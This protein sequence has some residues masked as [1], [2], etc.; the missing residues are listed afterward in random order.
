MR[1]KQFDVISFGTVYLDIDFLEFPFTEG[2]FAHRETVGKNYALEVGGSA[3]NFAKICANLNQSVLFIGQIGKDQIAPTVQALAKK[4]KVKTH[5]IQSSHVQ[6]NLAMHYVHAN[7]ESIMTS[8]G[9]ANQ[10]LSP[11]MLQVELKK[12]IFSTRYLYLGGGLKVLEL[13][14]AYPQIIKLAKQHGVKIILDHGRVTNLATNK[15]KIIIKSIISDVNIYLPS[16]DEFLDLWGF[17]S[18]DDGLKKLANKT[19]AIVVI[20][21]SNNGCY[22]IDNGKIIKVKPVSIIPINTIGSGDAFNA[23][24]IK[25]DGME[26]LNLKQK[27]QYASSTAAIKI[28]TNR[29]PTHKEIEELRD[30]NY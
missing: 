3:F 19:T 8:A 26:T 15:H 17:E 22:S 11:E 20:K 14:P 30:K 23:G 2:I 24:F 7:G 4:T 25:A 5:F 9:S 27:M 28:S 21:D 10:N 18:I 13:L 1:K 29:L 6:T 16:R 12:K